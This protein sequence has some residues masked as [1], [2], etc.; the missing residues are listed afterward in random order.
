LIVATY[1]FSDVDKFNLSATVGEIIS[2]AVELKG[3]EDI[4][5]RFL[6]FKVALNGGSV[7]VLQAIS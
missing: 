7:T 6:S 1:F 4:G 5:E 3:V 2:A